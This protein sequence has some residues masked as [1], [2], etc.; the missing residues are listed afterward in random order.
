LDELQAAYLNFRMKGLSADVRAR[1]KA[2]RSYQEALAGVPV[3]LR[4]E[5]T[6]LSTPFISFIKS[7]KRDGF[8]TI[9]A[10]RVSDRLHYPFPAHLQPALAA[11]ARIEGTL[12][13]TL[14]LQQRILSLPMFATISIPRSP[15][16]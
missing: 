14:R 12:N 13:A 5:R 3:E 4:V 2:A 9:C 7:D 11:N 8:A 10:K 16:V 1:R 6:A 15:R